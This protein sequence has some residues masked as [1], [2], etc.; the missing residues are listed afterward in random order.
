MFFPSDHL[1]LPDFATIAAGLLNAEGADVCCLVN[2]TYTDFLAY[3]PEAALFLNTAADPRAYDLAL[4]RGGATDGW[5]YDMDSYGV[6][7]ELGEW[8]IYCE[9]VNDVA[10]MALRGPGATAKYAKW[11]KQLHAEPIT[12]LLKDDDAPVPFSMLVD[13]WSQGLT[14]HYTLRR[15]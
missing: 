2:F 6:S 12:S 11:L 9:K 13:E 7:S 4:R 1:F 15:H 8:S 10:A 5:L 3:D 14:R